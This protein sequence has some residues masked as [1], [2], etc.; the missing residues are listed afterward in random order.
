MGLT[1]K[2]NKGVDFEPIPEDL[3]P[4]ICFAIWDVGTQLEE[5]MGH[6]KKVHRVVIAWELPNVRAKFEKE[7][8]SIDVPRTVSR[9]Y[10]L[11]LH[12]KAQLRKDLESWRGKQFTEDQLKGFDLRNVLSAPCQL[13]I[14]HNKE[15]DKTYANISAITKWTFGAPPPVENKVKFFSFEETQ[16]IPEGTPEWIVKLIQRAAEFQAEYGIPDD[17]YVP[18]GPD[19][20]VPF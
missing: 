15:G 20:D 10:R 3:H 16:A 13:Q 18:P 8:R 12:K 17:G 14:I 19:D 9:K 11:S 4:A 5:I 2:D 1:A 7:G 6:S